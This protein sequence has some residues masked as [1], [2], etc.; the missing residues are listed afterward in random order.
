MRKSLENIYT[1]KM[2]PNTLCCDLMT[3]LNNFLVGSTLDAPSSGESV[4]GGA[5]VV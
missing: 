5:P 3:S 4:F 1:V 2:F